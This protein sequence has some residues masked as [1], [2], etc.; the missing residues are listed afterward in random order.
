MSTDNTTEKLQDAEDALI[1]FYARVLE[2]E[3]ELAVSTRRAAEAEADLA[4]TREH[5]V[6]RDLQLAARIDELALAREQHAHRLAEL[7]QQLANALEEIDALHNSR[8]MRAV[9]VPRRIY[10]KLRAR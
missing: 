1:A 10:A 4:A 3:R 8:T 6:E 2:A 5:L 7:E 9:A